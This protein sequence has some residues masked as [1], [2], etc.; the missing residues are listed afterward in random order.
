MA[1]RSFALDEEG[2][3][4]RFVADAH[5]LVVEVNQQRWHCSG[6]SPGPSPILP[7]PMPA[8]LPGDSQDPEQEHRSEHDNTAAFLDI[9][10]RSR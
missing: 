1:Q 10:R 5:G 8:G 7:L 2:L 3:I 4:D 6:S 9:V